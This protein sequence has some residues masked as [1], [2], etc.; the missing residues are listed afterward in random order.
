MTTPQSGAGSAATD[1]GGSLRALFGQR[2]YRLFA[3]GQVVSI[4]GTWI[5]RIAQDWLVL[6]LSG[7]NAV[8]L[9]TAAAMQWGPTLVLSLW[10]G[11]IAD[12][13]TRRRFLMF[14]GTVLGGLSLLCGVL[15]LTGA[16]QLW[17]VLVLCLLAGAVS[18]VETPVRAAFTS[19]MVEPGQIATA[20]AVNSVVFNVARVTGPAVAG[21]LISVLGTGPLFVVDA[22][23]FG[24][25]VLALLRMRPGELRVSAVPSRRTKSLRESYREVLRHPGLGALIT[26]VFCLSA[27]GTSFVTIL[28]VVATQVFQRGAGGFGLLSSV[29]AAGALGGAVAATRYTLRHRP[30]TRLLAAIACLLG[31][32]EV[33]MGQLPTFWT[34]TVMLLC[35]GFVAQMFLPLAN[36]TVQL[37]VPAGQRGRVMALYGIA[38]VGAYPVGSLAIGWLAEAAGSRVAIVAGGAALAVAAAGYGLVTRGAEIPRGNEGLEET[39]G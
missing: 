6:H 24:A 29:L 2:N 22:V 15:V 8:A 17:Q 3:F 26:L 19:E 20:V 39:D 16:I 31:L 30:G 38:V 7:G 25:V 5:Q 18:A 12:R 13:V 4:T 11:D 1:R 9:G 14:S 34:F 35:C 32:G 36:S 21:A 28:A 23:S 33:V 27:M 37:S 10:A